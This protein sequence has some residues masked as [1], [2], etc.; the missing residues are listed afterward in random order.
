MSEFSHPIQLSELQ[1]KKLLKGHVVQIKKEQLH[2]EGLHIKVSKKTHTKIERAKRRST[3]L[4]LRLEPHELEMNGGSF[5]SIMKK[6]GKNVLKGLKT[7]GKSGL[8]QPLMTYGLSS[9][10]VDPA[11]ASLVST[12]TTKAVNGG[13]HVKPAFNLPAPPQPTAP[14]A[15]A[16][17]QGAGLV[18]STR[19][20][21]L[22]T[23]TK[24]VGKGKGLIMSCGRG[25][26]KKTIVL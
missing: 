7:V 17:P 23:S 21:G 20:N 5:K 4:R 26:N 6:V 25:I 19:G 1:Q 14:P 24:A 13:K 16:N 9:L 18:L 15:P 10:G 8:L 11:S 12:V 2:G 3:G 22:M